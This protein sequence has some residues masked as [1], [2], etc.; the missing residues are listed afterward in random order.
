VRM[1]TSLP[2]MPH[3]YTCR[4]GTV[5]LKSWIVPNQYRPKLRRRNSAALGLSDSVAL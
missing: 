3:T 2:Q 4:G 1:N 5:G